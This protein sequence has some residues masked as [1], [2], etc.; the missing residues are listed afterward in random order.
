MFSSLVNI[1]LSDKG[2]ILVSGSEPVNIEI[3]VEGSD[4]LATSKTCGTFHRF[5]DNV[6]RQN[7]A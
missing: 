6:L 7:T 3:L 5:G 2:T 4:S 1:S